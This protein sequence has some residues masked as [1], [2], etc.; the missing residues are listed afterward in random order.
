MPNGEFDVHAAVCP[1]LPR[2]ARALVVPHDIAVEALRAVHGHVEVGGPRRCARG[3]GDR[4]QL[5]ARHVPDEEH[6]A[7]QA[8][9]G[10]VGGGLL[11]PVEDSLEKEI[12]HV[13]RCSLWR[14]SRSCP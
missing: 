4:G 10:N 12:S 6:G 1:V 11:R 2:V 14:T 5:R 8:V 9:P 7:L 13:G 3:D